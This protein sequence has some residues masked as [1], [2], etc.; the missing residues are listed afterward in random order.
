MDRRDRLLYH[1]I[2][3]L[4]LA[5]DVATAGVA[6]F[7]FWQH[8]LFLGFAIGFGPSVLVTAALLTW[9]NL[10]RYAASAFGR[11]VRR[12]MTRWVEAARLAG[13]IPLWGGAWTHRPAIIGVG[14]LW[15]LCCWLWG[16]RSAPSRA[17]TP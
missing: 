8:E 17:P 7:A 6:A 1:Q 4:K 9:A 2:H 14:A 10:D 16:L 11:Y 15:I 3:P 12:F 13:L 5:T